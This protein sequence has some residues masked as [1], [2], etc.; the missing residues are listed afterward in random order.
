MLMG[1]MTKFGDQ[2]TKSLTDPH[3]PRRYFEQIDDQI[4]SVGD[5][6]N[7][8][9]KPWI[10]RVNDYAKDMCVFGGTCEPHEL[11]WRIMG[12]E[13]VMLKMGEDPDRFARIIDRLGDFGAAIADAQIKAAGGKLNGMYV[14]GDIAYVNGMMFNP[15]YWSE[16]YKPQLRKITDVIHGHGLKAIYHSDGDLHTIL[17]DLIDGGIDGLSKGTV[18]TGRVASFLHLGMIQYRLLTMFVVIVLL[19][20]YFFF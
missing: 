8:G 20:L 13:N 9:L 5:E 16:V 7:L 17:D 3:D 6:L 15:K 12:S 1:M 10:E 4:N 14:W 11:V 2:M 19:A 18:A